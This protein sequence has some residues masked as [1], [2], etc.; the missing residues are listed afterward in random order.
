MTGSRIVLKHILDICG[1]VEL[2]IGVETQTSNMRRVNATRNNVLDL[3]K[4]RM[5]S[6]NHPRASRSLECDCLFPR[7][8]D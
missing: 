6:T 8:Y 4:M 5:V 2:R 7:R 1:D 3:K